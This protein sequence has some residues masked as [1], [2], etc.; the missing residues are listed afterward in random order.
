M[1]QTI[2]SIG[3]F[4]QKISK[5]PINADEV[6][7]YRG[8]SDR[9]EF[10]LK[11]S[12]HRDPGWQDNEHLLVNELIS[13][14]PFDFR[15][16]ES[17]FEKL[18]RMQHHS[19]PTRLLDITSNPLMAL[20]FSAC[21]KNETAGEV[22][23]FRVK[24][25]AI[26]YSD[27]DTVSCIANVARLTSDDRSEIDTNLDKALF[28]A[29]GPIK[30]MLH[31]IKEEKPYFTDCIDPADMRSIV[32][33]RP[34]MSNLRISQQSGAFLLFGLEASLNEAGSADYPV[35]R[36]IINKKQK[37]KI[38]EQLASL[39][40]HRGTVYPNIDSSALVVRARY[41]TPA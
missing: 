34:R 15:E 9:H 10:K 3:G 40:I 28:N 20:Y 11:P 19:L 18:V 5:L 33:V 27:S 39:N 32:C 2:S 6:L 16:D 36:M 41:K 4:I 38:C 24:K 12:L 25:D 37:A 22:L 8:H 30:R 7:F 23:I 35:E 1:S 29:S 17:M 26:K 13:S 31:F 21:E 14:N